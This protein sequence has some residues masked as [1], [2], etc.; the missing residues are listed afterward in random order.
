MRL[1]ILAAAL[2]LGGCSTGG[3]GAS[4]GS[5]IGRF[6]PGNGEPG[7]RASQSIV[8]AMGEGLVGAAFSPPLGERDRLRALEAEYRALEYGSAGQAVAWKSD[9]GIPSGEVVAFQPYRVGSQDCRQYTHTVVAGS[10]TR[11]MRG[12]ACRN[13]DGSWTP[14]G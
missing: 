2:A 9:K 12:T 7:N 5:L 14:L 3:S 6:A 8:A 4:S 10:E 1:A 11:S 13:E